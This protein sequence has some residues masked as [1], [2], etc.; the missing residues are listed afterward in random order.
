MQADQ[1]RVS[2]VWAD[3]VMADIVITDPAPISL[4]ATEGATF[5]IP[6][7]D[8]PPGFV[9]MSPTS[10]GYALNLVSGMGGRVS[11]AGK[12]IDVEQLVGEN[13]RAGLCAMRIG[14]GD[15]GVIELDD[16]GEH[17]VFFQFV[18]AT[19]PLP[20]PTWR[21][22]ETLLPPLTFALLLHAVV[23]L[24]AVTA[25]ADER[26]IAFEPGVATVADY[27][28]IDRPA[29]NANEPEPQGSEPGDAPASAVLAAAEP[30][31]ERKKQ[32]PKRG[33]PAK[34]H[35]GRPD[36]ATHESDVDNSMLP[37]QLRSALTKSNKKMQRFGDKIDKATRLGNFGNETGSLDDGGSSLDTKG[38][39]NGGREHG[40]GKG[41]IGQDDI[42]TETGNK[43]KHNKRD[44]EGGGSKPVELQL[45]P[46]DR[47]V[48]G[49]SEPGRS[50]KEILRVV[51][52]RAPA[53]R[54]CYERELQR[55]AGLSGKIVL[56]WTITPAGKVTGVRVSNAS[57]N[58]GRVRDCVMRVTRGLTFEPAKGR[59]RVKFPF[60]FRP[61]S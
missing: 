13:G 37:P 27:P 35:R 48:E 18:S 11:L 3:D 29:E 21:D 39:G 58:N 56:V 5:A 51:K 15:W 50:D 4:G 10:V 43:R 8:L 9:L 42:D 32:A 45:P 6:H 2:Y 44:G 28:P 7:L 24:F 46:G 38:D 17:T 36:A 40:T 33:T 52:R 25:R 12:D 20:K 23:V 61:G 14:A 22:R 53:Y 55:Q 59:S 19:R 31:P 26:V 1:L 30:A 49:P 41:P 47:H 60:L 57:L 16:A 54:S 34:A